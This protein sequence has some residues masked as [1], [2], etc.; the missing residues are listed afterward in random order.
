M[1]VTD[2]GKLYIYIC[3]TFKQFNRY[4]IGWVSVNT[5]PEKN[6]EDVMKTIDIRIND[7][8]V[9]GQEIEKNR[10]VG[11]VGSIASVGD[12]SNKKKYNSSVGESKSMLSLIRLTSALVNQID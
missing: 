7:E 5:R 2:E 1:L 3:N 9:E 10:E 11:S 8:K 6:E 4:L 12:Y